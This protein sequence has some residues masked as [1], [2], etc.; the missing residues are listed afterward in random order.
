MSLVTPVCS[1][2]L[3]IVVCFFPQYIVKV[4][5]HDLK[6]KLPVEKLAQGGH[7]GP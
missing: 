4:F 3:T 6:Q 2:T 5:V 7:Y 1:G